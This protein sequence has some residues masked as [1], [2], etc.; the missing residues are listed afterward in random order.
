M[1]S[2]TGTTE[3]STVSSIICDNWWQSKI[4]ALDCHQGWPS[5]NAW[6]VCHRHAPLGKF[7]RGIWVKPDDLDMQQAY[8]T[9]AMQAGHRPGPSGLDGSGTCARRLAR[10]RVLMG[11]SNIRQ[12][13]HSPTPAHILYTPHAHTLHSTH[14]LVVPWPQPGKSHYTTHTTQY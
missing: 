8:S 1:H 11:P 13:T 3:C 10:Q 14:C 5:L 7:A 2:R 4:V 6:L 9:G 12:A